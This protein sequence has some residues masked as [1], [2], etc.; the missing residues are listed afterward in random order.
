MT[1]LMSKR[2]Q[3]EAVAPILG[4]QLLDAVQKKGE[5]DVRVGTGCR[6]IDQDVLLGGFRYGEVICLCASSEEEQGRDVVSGM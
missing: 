4:S 6:D 3:S 1:A 2:E 5:I